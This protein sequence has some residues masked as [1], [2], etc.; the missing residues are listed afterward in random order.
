M[1][2][3]IHCLVSGRVQGVFYR[4]GT[5]DYAGNLGLRGWVRN[6]PEGGVEVVACGEDDKLKQLQ[7]WLWQGS[8]HARVTG[9]QCHPTSGK[10]VGAGFEVR[11]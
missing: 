2:N 4:A 9:V 3:C 11:Y 10:D 6:M 7:E 8:P 1:S 5:H